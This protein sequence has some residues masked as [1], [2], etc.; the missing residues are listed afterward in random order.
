MQK[1]FL[2]IVLASLPLFS[3]AQN[4]DYE[5]ISYTDFFTLIENE[6]DSTLRLS[7]LII[8]YNSES[9]SMHYYTQ[10]PNSHVQMRSSYIEVDKVV[11]LT[12]VHFDI[13]EGRNGHA[14]HH[15]HFK[16][17]VFMLETGSVLFDYCRFDGRLTIF[18]E[19]ASKS[20]IQWLEH[21]IDV[22]VKPIA[23]SNSYFESGLDLMVQSPD[24][25]LNAYVY[26]GNC[27]INAPE[28]S[29]P[30]ITFRGQGCRNMSIRNNQLKGFNTVNIMGSGNEYFTVA[31]NEMDQGDLIMSILEQSISSNVYVV[32]NVWSRYV[33]LEA[34][35]LNSSAELDWDQFDGKLYN[36]RSYL[37]YDNSTGYNIPSK[38]ELDSMKLQ[39]TG[40]AIINTEFFY[41][42]EIKLRGQLMD[43]YESQFNSNRANEVYI[44]LKNLETQRFEFLYR[45]QPGFD[46]FFQWKIN[47]FLKIFSD[48]G[49]KPSKA[50]V[51]SLWVILIFA[52]FYLFSPNSWYTL[53]QNRLI[54]RIRFFTKY[55]R[56]KEGMQEVYKEETRARVLNYEEFKEYM[57]ESKYEVPKYFMLVSKPLYYF[58]LANYTT[59]SAVLRKLDILKGKWV[60][61]PRSRRLVTSFVMALWLIFMIIYDLSIK[62][63]NAV[64]LSI[65]TFTTLGFGEIPIKGIA[66]YLAIIQGFIGWF[67]L[68]LF[69]VSLI[70]QLMH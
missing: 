16:R 18:V 60:E 38:E 23:V 10:D 53:N 9:D 59:T 44:D 12:N 5:V 31:G 24:E 22:G 26:I 67:M 48:Y 30:I 6:A 70:T 35:A 34:E 17:D 39:Y 14:L 66:R 42:Q 43:L 65:N 4:V 68:S 57:A 41:N 63:L 32:G 47:R 3:I 7:D 49:T 21:N 58:S 11:F 61:L 37:E 56:Q 54:N 64:I 46:T 55:F 27:E 62:V 36:Y 15:I 25:M 13:K 28:K 2:L 29:L 51:F 69:S 8:R 20:G 45:Q 50:I 33:F 52:L 40:Q 1:Q 19:G